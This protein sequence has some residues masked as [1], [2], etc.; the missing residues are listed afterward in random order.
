MCGSG[1]SDC[2]GPPLT[3]PT[4]LGGSGGGGEG[5]MLPREI[6]NNCVALDCVF[7]AVTLKIK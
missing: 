1:A 7:K 3:K 5:G 2:L 4:I 6:L